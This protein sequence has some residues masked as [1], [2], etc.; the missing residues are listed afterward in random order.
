MNNN[1]N[2]NNNNSERDNKLKPSRRLLVSSKHG[3]KVPVK[4]GLR[5]LGS[6]CGLEASHCAEIVCQMPFKL[7]GPVQRNK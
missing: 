2:N 7:G 3:E 5:R 4:G 6:F 1:N